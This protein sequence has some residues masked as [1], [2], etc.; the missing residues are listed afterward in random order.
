MAARTLLDMMRYRKDFF[1]AGVI[2]YLID[3]CNIIEK[4]PWK[5]LGT[6]AIGHR[7]SNAVNTVGFRSRGER[8]G[9]VSQRTYE[10]VTDATYPM[11]AEIEV[12]KTDFRDKRLPENPLV[13]ATKE[14]MED[15]GWTFRNHFLNGDQAT[16]PKGFDGVLVRLNNLAASQRVYAQDSSNDLD[17]RV[18]ATVTDAVARQVLN[19]I[20]ETVAALDGY[21]ADIALTSRDV[22]LALKRVMRQ[23]NYNV[24]PLVPAADPGTGRRTSAQRPSK[25][26]L[27]YEGVSFYDLGVQADQSTNIVGTETIGGQATTP[28][29]FLKLGDSYLTGIQQYEIEVSETQLDPSDMVTYRTTVDWPVG[30]HHVHPKFGARLSGLFV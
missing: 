17:I 16:E 12:D 3:E 28:I 4:I 29:F 27:V 13:T 11:G 9:A 30:L 10:E 21:Q 14:A 2:S 23:L 18:T 5:T 1:E 19:R 24:S 26:N 20:D 22:I 6:T 25:P 7:R 8:F 15:V